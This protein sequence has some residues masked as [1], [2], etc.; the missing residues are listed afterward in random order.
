MN[1]SFTVINHWF[2]T[3][4]AIALAIVAAGGSLSGCFLPIVL[5]ILFE[6]IGSFIISCMPNNEESKHQT[7]GSLAR[8]NY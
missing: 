7:Q 4:R 1:P 3:K 2:S 5:S 8:Y 6:K